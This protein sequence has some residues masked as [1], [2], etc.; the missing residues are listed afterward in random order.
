MYILRCDMWCISNGYSFLKKAKSHC[1]MTLNNM[2]SWALRTCPAASGNTYVV[3]SDHP[4]ASVRASAGPWGTMVISSHPRGGGGE[5]GSGSSWST[6]E[7][8]HTM[9]SYQQVMVWRGGSRYSSL[10]HLTYLSQRTHP[11]KEDWWMRMGYTSN[12]NI[13]GQRCSMTWCGYLTVRHLELLKTDIYNNFR[14]NIS[15][16]CL[17]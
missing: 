3:N 11:F 2:C 4:W 16:I 14:R 8:L 15:V 5:E 13:L 12:L 7:D 9:V 10:L 17:M 6:Q 1:P